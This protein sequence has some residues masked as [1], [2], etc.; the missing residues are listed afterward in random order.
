MSGTK[1]N[2]GILIETRPVSIPRRLRIL[3]AQK[4]FSMELCMIPRYLLA[5]LK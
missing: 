1:L 5:W 3:T 2:P 4:A